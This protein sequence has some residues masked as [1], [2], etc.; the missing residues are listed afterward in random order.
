V[1]GGDAKFR[2]RAVEKL[3]GDLPLRPTEALKECPYED[4]DSPSRVHVDPLGNVHICQGISMGN[5]WETPLSEL[6]KNYNSSEHPV[7]APLLRGGP[8]ELAKEWGISPEAGY[9]DECHFY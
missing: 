7:C 9:I 2:G 1:I 6:V 4:L 3:T 8:A 5:M